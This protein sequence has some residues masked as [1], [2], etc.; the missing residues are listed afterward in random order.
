MVSHPKLGSDPPIGSDRESGCDIGEDEDKTITELESR[1][2]TFLE[3]D[4]PLRGV[5]DKNL[6]LYEMM[7]LD[8]NSK[9]EQ[10]LMI[11]ES[12]SQLVPI[13]STVKEP[14]LRQISCQI[15]PR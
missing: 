2:V 8:I 14:I 3:D 11:K 1:D 9:S 4:F 6:H 13:E 7:D 5:I 10:Q 15:I 12:G